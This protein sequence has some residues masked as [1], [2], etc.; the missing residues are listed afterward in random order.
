MRKLFFA[1][2]IVC[3]SAFSSCSSDEGKTNDLDGILTML[4]FEGF[5]N[6][7]RAVFQ[8][9]QGKT[10]SFIL[11]ID[12]R[13]LDIN[14]GEELISIPQL[15]FEYRNITNNIDI[16]NIS[17]IATIDNLQ[18]IG[19]TE[20]IY[21]RISDFLSSIIENKLEIV[22][23]MDYGNTA[24]SQEFIWM[25]EK[26]ENVYSN[27]LIEENPVNNVSLFYQV[28]TGIIGFNDRKGISWIF[29]G[30]E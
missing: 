28:P 3:I 14:T 10:I 15:T 13:V 2:C 16:P 23:D 27:V 21:C 24:L 19:R 26:F 25:G 12:D 11:N 18:D 5:N 17:V 4:P 20:V 1:L 30:Y 9:T 29:I 8:N 7:S 22:Q 6:N